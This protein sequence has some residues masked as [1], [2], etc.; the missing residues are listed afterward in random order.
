MKKLADAVDVSEATIIEGLEKAKRTLEKGII[1]SVK[2]TSDQPVRTRGE[3]LEVYL[4]ALLL[5]GRTSEFYTDLIRL[6]VLEDFSLS[7]VRELIQRLGG[8]VKNNKTFNLKK[9]ADQLPPEL[10]ST[11]DEAALMDL[12]DIV[13]DNNRLEREWVNATREAQKMIVKR[14]MNR[15]TGVELRD[16]TRKLS[17]LEKQAEI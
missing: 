8:F 5:Q 12:S 10:I 17:K 11:L 14:K 4:L 2:L 9:F 3:K 15:V 1:G 16:L 6:I 13:E 7:P